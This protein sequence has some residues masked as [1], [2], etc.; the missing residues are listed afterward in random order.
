M[1]VLIDNQRQVETPEGVVLNICLAGVVTRFAAAFVDFLIRAAVYIVFGI[2]ISIIFSDGVAGGFIMLFIFLLEWF[3]PIIFE[4]YKD[5]QTPGK[6]QMKIKVLHGDGTPIDWQASLIR[7]FLRAVD[8]LPFFYGFGVVSVFFSKN[9]SRLGDIAAN[10][11]VVYAEDISK[12]KN[13]PTARSLAPK[14]NLFPEEQNAVVNF[15]SRSEQLSI[16]RQAELAEILEPL[17]ENKDEQSIQSLF[18]YANHY[19]GE[20]NL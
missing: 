5:G 4:I 16:H 9:F 3:Y 15:A 17:H 20:E 19:A 8:F 10:T 12:A 6:K 18:Q 14:Q 1:F 2:A 11:I 13:I 7:N